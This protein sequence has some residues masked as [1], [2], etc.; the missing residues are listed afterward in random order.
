MK[1]SIYSDWRFYAA[2]FATIALYVVSIFLFSLKTDWWP[3]F[4]SA[5]FLPYGIF[6]VIVWSKFTNKD[7]AIA[8][9]IL[10]A[11]WTLLLLPIAGFIIFSVQVFF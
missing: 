11:S 2:Y 4:A 9:G 8:L 1:N 7:S 3:I 5:L 6:G 10:F